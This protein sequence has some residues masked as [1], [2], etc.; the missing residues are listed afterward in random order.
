MPILVI[1][2][3]DAQRQVAASI[4]T[5]PHNSGRNHHGF[6][7]IEV[8]VVVFIIGIMAG[9]AVIGLGGGGQERVQEQEAH[10]F[11][12]LL[13]LARDEGIL[14]GREY[15]VGF[16]ENSYS[17]LRRYRVDEQLYEWLPVEE[18]RQL[19]RRE[20]AAKEIR[21]ELYREGIPVALPRESKTPPA[22]IIL[23]VSGEITPFALHLYATG[24]DLPV[25]KIEGGADGR[26]RMERP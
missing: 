7:L 17:F 15:A 8:V 11:V 23:G 3:S 26:I 22:H 2:T 16:T 10:R 4:S 5:A 1:G 14:L 6:T 25:W 24:E 12:A 20:I 21:L 18:D 19:R 9:F 13:E